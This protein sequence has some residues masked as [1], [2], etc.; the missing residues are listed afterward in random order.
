[1]REKFILALLA[2][3]TLYCFWQHDEQRHFSQ[4]QPLSDIGTITA[5]NARLGVSGRPIL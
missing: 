3:L 1:M 2:T 4:H 5:K